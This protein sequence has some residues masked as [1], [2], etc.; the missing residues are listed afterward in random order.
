MLLKF[1]QNSQDK[2][3][4]KFSKSWK[5][6]DRFIS[7][8]SASERFF[9]GVF[10]KV[11]SFSSSLQAKLAA[12]SCL[13]KRILAESSVKE[14]FSTDTWSKIGDL[15]PFSTTFVTLLDFC[16]SGLLLLGFLVNMNF[17]F[18]YL[19]LLFIFLCLLQLNLQN[20]YTITI[21]F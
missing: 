10:S 3:E 11:F 12:Q 14:V 16:Y 1:L 8:E 6:F 9:T 19:C 21:H 7:T 4:H 2:T 20:L 18:L 5:L 17:Y 13:K 15:S